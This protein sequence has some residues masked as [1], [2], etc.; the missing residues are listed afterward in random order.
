MGALAAKYPDDDEAKIFYA[1]ALNES[2]DH[3]D[4]TYSALIQAGE[5]LEPLAR[6]YPDHPGIPHYIIHSMDFAPLAQRGLAAAEIY[7]KI[8]PSS[9]HALHMPSH[10]YSML[11]RWE[12]SIV[13]NRRSIAA[14]R[15]YMAEKKLDGTYPGELHSDDFIEYAYL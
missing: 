2:W 9:P 13:T 15:R 14:G 10:I 5:N 11:G 3:H 1:L 12:N 6:K 4:K 8:A 7:D